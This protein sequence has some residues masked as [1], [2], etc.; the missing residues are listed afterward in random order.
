MK[1]PSFIL[2]FCSVLMIASSV[3]GLQLQS[4]LAGAASSGRRAPALG[5]DMYFSGGPFLLIDGWKDKQKG[6]EM[7]QAFERAG[8][9]TFRIPFAGVYSP[10][11]PEAT[12]AVKAENKTTNEFPWFRFDIVADY[13]AAHDFTAVIGV[14]VEE[15]PE[16]AADVVRLFIE[17]G[18]KNKLVAVELS[19]EP[20]LNQR[21]WLPEDFAA[22]AAAVIE[23]LTP[24][25]VRFALP[26][27]V[28]GDN[29]TPTKLSDNE[30]NA[31]MLRALSA[32]I[33]LKNRTDIYGAIHLYSRGVRSETI[34]QF[35][36]AVRPFAPNMRYL[37]TEFNIRLGLEKNQHL[38][39]EYAL[40]FAEKLAELMN[41]PEIEAMYVHAVP[42]YSI[43]YWTNGKR[44]TTV[45]RSRDARLTGE[46]MTRGWHLTPAG[47]VYSL[48][49][50]L[51]WNGEVITYKED[52]KQRYW[53]VRAADGRLVVTLLNAGGG[54]SKKKVKIEGREIMLVAPARSIVVFDQNGRELERLSLPQ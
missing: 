31:R 40:E 39:N 18:I 14:N 34:D 28:G 13:L 22:R 11:G 27:T 38:T 54:Q 33:D 36:K 26:L 10:R 50:H 15:S 47:R 29:N 20:H 16:V 19:N 35:N 2:L 9:R 8:L 42:Y 6:D 41:R 4:S 25:G 24:L 45:S 1:K 49:S 52:G 30:Y 21:P 53:A 7:A 3:S 48:Y 51:S 37:V 5:G 12:T 46:A 32:R 43:M 23:R 17:R 44:V